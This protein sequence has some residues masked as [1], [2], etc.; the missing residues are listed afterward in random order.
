MYRLFFCSLIHSPHAKAVIIQRILGFAIHLL[1]L[2]ET[3]KAMQR[4]ESIRICARI[5]FM[6]SN[7]L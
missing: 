5:N 1:H 7:L 6:C 3:L 4:V 2:Y